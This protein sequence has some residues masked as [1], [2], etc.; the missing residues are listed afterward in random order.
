MSRRIVET[1][2]GAIVLAVAFGFLAWAYSRSN[3]A[4][5]DGYTLYAR[6]DSIDGLEIGADVRVSGIRV[7]KV[8]GAELDPETYRA[9]VAFDVRRDLELPRDSSAAVVSSGLFGSKYLAIVPGAEPEMLKPGEEITLTQ[10]SI[11]L[12]TLIG[13]FLFGGT[14]GGSQEKGAP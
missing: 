12:E 4:R 6:F 9:R 14:V 1:L 3:V 8:T 2:L 5:P 13:K 10:S 11:N 7:G